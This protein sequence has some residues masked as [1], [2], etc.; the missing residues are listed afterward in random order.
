M[1][2]WLLNILVNV[3]QLSICVQAFVREI[4]KKRCFFFIK[5]NNLQQRFLNMS[6]NVEFSVDEK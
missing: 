5:N 1:D 4:Y 2:K 6:L 3:G